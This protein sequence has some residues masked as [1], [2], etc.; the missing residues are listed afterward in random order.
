MQ[1]LSDFGSATGTHELC[2]MID[3]QVFSQGFEPMP[4][5]PIAN[6]DQ[7]QRWILL[8]NQF[9]SPQE[10]INALSF[11]LMGDTEK[12]SLLERFSSLP[13]QLHLCHVQT[14]VYRFGPSL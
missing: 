11:I 14:I 1:Q 8:Q 6:E 2:P 12:V 10:D 13:Q 3:A 7:L 4:Q 9:E 5:G